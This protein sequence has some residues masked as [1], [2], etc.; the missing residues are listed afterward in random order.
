[1]ANEEHLAR[2]QQGVEAWNRWRDEHPE[3]RPDLT[4]AD[5][6]EADLTRVNLAEA[7]LAGA[8][9][10]A[11]NLCKVNL[12]GANLAGANLTGARIGGTVFGDI[13]LSTV[14]GL[15]TLEHDRPSIIGIDT[16]YRSHGDIPEAF[17]LG[18]GVPGDM[19]TYLKSLVG[20]P[21]LYYSCFISYSTRDEALA[22]RLHADLQATGVRC[23]FAPGDL[24][25]GDEFRSRIDELVQVHDRLL[26]VLSEHSVKS[27][28]I[29]KE[30]ETAF[31]KEGRESRMV[32]FPIRIDEAVMQSEV[33]WAADI[34]R[35]RHIG[36]FRQWKDHDAYQR[37]F[38]RLLHD[39]K[40]LFCSVHTA[41]RRVCRMVKHVTTAL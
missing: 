41:A 5:L 19:I 12:T 8:N 23:W 1:V 16:L 36:D 20:T 35:Q 15:D 11:A 22:Q 30:V 14:R 24:K 21:F 13:D 26:L 39:L 37:A 4:S 40:D 18:T 28:W 33:G 29:Q 3:I 34:R 25:I 27:H 7:D 32:L 6:A 38:N 31:E 17:L 10:A 2:L 9:L